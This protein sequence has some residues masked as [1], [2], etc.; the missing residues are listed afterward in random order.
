V[1]AATDTRALW[2]LTRGTGVVSLLLL[3][4]SVVLGI[5][6]VSRVS[7]R[8][9]PRFVTAALH[10]QVSLLVMAFLGLHIL[11]AIADSFVTIRWVDVVVPFTG[12]YRPMWLGLGAVAFDL[13]IALIVTSLLRQRIG[14]RA[15]RAVHWAAYASFPIALL[16]GFGIGTDTRTSWLFAVSMA[17]VAAVAAAAA[18]RVGFRSPLG[19]V[20]AVRPSR[21]RQA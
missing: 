7:S 16:H 9:F 3:T 5:T 13:L 2:Y 14:Y 12:T 8:S 17:C 21:T 20:G 6:Q 4:L 19:S 15:W 1:I 18:W 11:T 10:K